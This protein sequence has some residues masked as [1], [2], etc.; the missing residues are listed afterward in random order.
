MRLKILTS[1]SVL[2]LFFGL[3]A[4]VAEAN[5]AEVKTKTSAEVNAQEDQNFIEDVKDALGKTKDRI[6]DGTEEAAD[7]VKEIYNEVK[8]T[9]F[10]NDNNDKGTEAT[11]SAS[12][13]AEGMLGEPV[14]NVAGERIGTL[15]DIIL[16]D[17]GEAVLAVVSD[18]E[19]IDLGAKEV[20]F[21]Y[22]LVA[23]REKDGDVIMPLTEEA[24]NNAKAFSYDLN[25]ANDETRAIPANGYSIEKL[26][27]T[28]VL[29]PDNNTVGNVDN[30]IFKEGRADLV[31]VGFDKIL[32]MGGKKA[33]LAFQ[34]LQLVRKNETDAN[35]QLTASQSA[36]FETFKQNVSN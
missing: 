4:A 2:A 1:V 35:F 21:D 30:V 13:T 14:N 20:A 28:D 19:L 10:Q 32:N 22:A 16:N 12:A 25:A 3:Q 31:I 17:K 5:N 33:A 24:I 9:R 23:R 26:L 29:G 8:Y 18:S 6:V 15:K 7:A 34:D 36:Q 11:I 27:G